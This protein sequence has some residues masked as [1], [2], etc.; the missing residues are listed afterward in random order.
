ME[1]TVLIERTGEIAT[2][3]MN[4]PDARNALSRQLGADLLTAL[5]DLSRDEQLRA[6]ILTGAG[7]RAF[8]AGADLIER[9][10]LTS[11]ELTTHTESINAVCD[12]LAGFPVPT[13]A[14]IRGFALAGGAELAIACDLRIAGEDAVLGFPEV[15]IGVFPGA[16]GVVRLPRLV[17]AGAARDLRYTGRKVAADEALRIGLV[18]RIV[19]SAQVLAVARALADEIAA[20]APLAVRAVK[21]ALMESSGLAE[22]DAHR[23]VARHRRPLDATADYEE[24]LAAFAERRRPAFRGE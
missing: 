11:A 12:A 8:C 17:G 16:G 2:V 13:F 22:S 20:N 4:R 21:R 7:E 5:T 3:T 1:Q 15:K 14:A 6:L 18:D 19:P 24:G 9:R 10:T 23:V